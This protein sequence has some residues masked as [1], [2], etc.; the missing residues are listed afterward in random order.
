MLVSL[1]FRL[2]PSTIL[3]KTQL[4]KTEIKRCAKP[5]HGL[6]Q[7]FKAGRAFGRKS[8]REIRLCTRERQLRTTVE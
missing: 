8:R 6:K 1:R 4:C 5:F 7:R 2:S 3:N